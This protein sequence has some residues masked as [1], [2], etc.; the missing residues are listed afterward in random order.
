MG[1]ASAYQGKLFEEE[2]RERYTAIASNREGSAEE[3]LK[4]YNQ[5]GE[6]IENRM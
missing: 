1:F 6:F 4:W 5:R 3:V 2:D